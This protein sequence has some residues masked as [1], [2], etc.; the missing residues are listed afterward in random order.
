MKALGTLYLAIVIAFAFASCGSEKKV[1]TQGPQQ[2]LKQEETRITDQPMHVQPINIP[3][4]EESKDDEQYYR[5]L[6]IGEVFDM[7]IF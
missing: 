2:Q 1:V 5:A 3:C 4:K 7:Q 6:G